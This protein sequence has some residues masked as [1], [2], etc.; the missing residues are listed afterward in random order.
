MDCVCIYGYALFVY[1]PITVRGQD[2]RTP[3]LIVQILAV[4]PFDWVRWM[5]VGIAATISSVF[6]A[7]NLFMVRY[8]PRCMHTLTPIRN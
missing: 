1:I 7:G 8:L 4:I 5:L 3:L 2:Q 6:L